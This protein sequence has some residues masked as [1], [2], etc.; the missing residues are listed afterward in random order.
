VKM[1]DYIE[2]GSDGV[3]RRSTRA[4]IPPVEY[5]NGQQ[6]VYV[7]SETG[8]GRVPVVKEYFLIKSDDEKPQASRRARSSKVKKEDVPPVPSEIPVI[9]YL[10]NKEELQS[11]VVTSDMLALKYMGAGSYKFQK[12]FSEGNLLASG[13]LV[14]P[15]GSQKPPK[16]SG[17][18]ALIFMVLSGQ[19]EVQVHSSTFTISTGAQF[20]VPRGN[21]YSIAN[22]SNRE[23]RLFF[24]Y[25]TGNA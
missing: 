15:K 4:R 18:S 5:W 8:V 6:V 24:C 17:N 19:I 11:V 3:L 21:S 22:A 16:S 10:S 7:P 12:V 2:E 13:I 9:N 20:L 1:E 25:G 23:A 14:L